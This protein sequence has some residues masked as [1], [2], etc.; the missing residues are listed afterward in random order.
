MKK[1]YY[2][3]FA[4][5]L[6]LSLMSMAC[7]EE[8][9][10]KPPEDQVTIDN[11]YNTAEQLD[12]SSASLYGAPWFTFNDKANWV[13]G[14]ALS[15]NHW[16]NDGQMA[17][18]FAFGVNADNPH[19]SEAWR[20]LWGVIA[21]ANIL[22]ND[23]PSRV[24]SGV[25]QS[26]VDQ[27]VA[28]AK[29][30]RGVAYFYLVRLWHTAPI[31]TNNSDLIDD[32]IVPKNRAEDIYQFVLQDLTDAEA[33]LPE[34][35]AEPGRVTSWS[36]KGMKA[37]V[38]LTRS[39]LNQNGSRNQDDLNAARD[40][41]ADVINNSGLSLVPGYDDLFR[42]ENENNSETLFALQWVSCL[43]WGTQNT[44]Q[45]YF[46][47]SGSIAGVGDG[48]GGF[49]GPTVDL[50]NAYETGDERMDATI[51]T[52][53]AHYPELMSAEGGYTYV[54][55]PNDDDDEN[56]TFAAIRKYVVGGPN[57]NADCIAFMS[58][59]LNTYI[60][61]LADVYLIYAEAILG[62]QGSTS[63]GEALMAIN[64][65]R[66][67]AGLSDL[68]SVTLDDILHERRIEFAY[69]GDY[70][71]DMVR[72]HYY[73]ASK[74]IDILAQQERGTYDWEND[75]PFLTSVSYIPTDGDFIL[76]YPATESD[77]NPLLLEDAVP[78]EF[79]N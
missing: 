14:D 9:L 16:T 12:G 54:V 36:A 40:L 32:P 69:E 38:Y 78:Y 18:F 41:A 67:R 28:E 10:E 27:V 59:P 26:K 5:L 64:T 1:I 34:V 35:A 76:P 31:I 43:D 60:Q 55:D 65:V 44:H 24:G 2:S 48:W 63:D 33:V 61:R 22:I 3:N 52:D 57:D 50:Q 13:I 45:A 72:L 53:G 42:T 47:P 7:T 11:F 70:W 17:Q 25:S 68:S 73:N 58:S 46:T 4:K 62:N 75:L 51:M 37:K 20:S 15:G 49:I 19:V 71:Y 8:F 39:G 29:F 6:A 30:M 66:N 56:A 23:M 77:R 21:N 74:A 79:A